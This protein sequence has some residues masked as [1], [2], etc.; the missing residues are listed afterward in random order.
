MY[1]AFVALLTCIV[2][3]VSVIVQLFESRNTA[4]IWP[5]VGEWF[6]FWAV[7][8]RLL[9]AGLRQI[10]NPQFTAERI[11]NIKSAEPLPVVRELGFA[12]ASTG[13]LGISALFNAG[14]V[15]PAAIVG[16]LFYGLAGVG[17]AFKKKRNLFEN[18][19]MYSD[20]LVFIVL[21]AYVIATVITW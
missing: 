16:G 14:W 2:P 12:N 7:G 15:M 21:L 19:A 4:G 9:I 18:V 17:H 6:V 10:A 5:L 11:F 8:V 20:L 13:I 3:A 1:I